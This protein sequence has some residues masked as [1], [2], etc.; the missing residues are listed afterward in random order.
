MWYDSKHTLI[1]NSEDGYNKVFD[2]Y[3]RYHKH[4]DSFYDLDI[5]RFLPRDTERLDVV[6]LWA[7]DGR[8]YKYF[9]NIKLNSYTAC[10]IADKLLNQHPKWKNNVKTV[11]CDLEE[12]LQFDNDSFDLAM[13]FFVLEHISDLNSFFEE[14]YR[15]L[16]PGGKFIVWHFLQRREFEWNVGTWDQ[17]EK[18][19]IKQYR[20]K[21][22][23]IKKAAEYSFFD[24]YYQ[25]I[26]DSDNKKTLIWYL[27]ICEKK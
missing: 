26:V 16:K 11:V 10:D 9:A 17:N 5:Q 1:L 4:L 2:Q 14:T 23:D 7:G 20:Y 24:F 12:R 18:F 8:L 22:E 19:K 15:I 3:K 6:D 25:E 13:S 27:I 21:L